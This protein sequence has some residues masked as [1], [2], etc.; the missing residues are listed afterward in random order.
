MRNLTRLLVLAAC[1]AA[2]L[3]GPRL[4]A[5]EA[6]HRIRDLIYRKKEGV[7]LTMDVLQPPK[8]TGVGVLW[9]VSGGWFSSHAN[10]EGLVTNGMMKGFLDRGQT[11]FLVVHGSQPRFG[12]PDILPDIDRATRYIRAHA[13]ELGVDPNRLGI[14]G[15]SAGGHLSLMQGARGSEG[16]PNAPDPIDRVSSKVQAVACFFPPTDF[17]NWGSTGVNALTV[18]NLKPFYAPFQAASREP[19]ELARACKFASPVTYVGK[20]MP[21]TL[22]IHG[23]KDAL[24]PIQQAE[25]WDKRLEELGVPHRLVVRPGQGHGWATLGQDIAVLAEWID[26]HAGKK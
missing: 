15:G 24:V 5:Q 8:P 4:R 6:P 3:I 25:V 18:E 12:I 22:I 13:D 11:V 1:A 19:D 26:T 16:N 14:G 9:M 23:D 7:A 2:V 10:L 17:L 20:H 21:P